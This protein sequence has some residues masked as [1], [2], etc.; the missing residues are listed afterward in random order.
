MS[1]RHKL[2][3]W[4][5]TR[6]GAL[7]RLGV[8]SL[9]TSLTLLALGAI[10]AF[11]IPLP[12]RLGVEDSTL[13]TYADGT[14]AHLELSRDDDRWR[15]GI[16]LEEVDP[17]YV[18]ALILL[19]DQ[20]FW[21]HPGVDPIAIGRAT[22]SNLTHG[23]VVSGASTIT[24]QLVRM[25]EPRPRTLSSKCIEALRA[26]QLELRLSKKEILEHYVRFA[27]YGRNIEGL[28]AASMAYFGHR[29]TALSNSEIAILLAVPQAPNTRYPST[30]NL[31]RLQRARDQVASELLAAGALFID[32][33]LP[34]ARG[35]R[36]AHE[37]L[38]RDPLPPE[39]LPFPREIPHLAQ[40][41]ARTHPSS[42][43][44]RTSI[45]R[46]LQ[47]NLERL[48][49]ERRGDLKRAQIHH[50]AVVVA[51]QKSDE[52]VGL[53]GNLGFDDEH[54]SQIAAFDT[55]RSTGSLLK[56]V[57]MALAID[58]GLTHPEQLV[59]DVPIERQRWRPSNF[60]GEF[61]GLVKL[62]DALIRSLNIPFILLIEELGVEKLLHTLRLAR[63]THL[64]DRPGHYGLNI[65]VGGVDATPL[66]MASLYAAFA[67][68]GEHRRLKILRGEGLEEDSRQL[69]T[70]GANWLVDRELAR[71][72]RPDLPWRGERQAAAVSAPIH[73]KTGTSND[74][75]D[76]WS[77]GH[78]GDYTVAVWLGNLDHASSGALVGAQTAAPLM[79]DV[80][81]ALLSARTEEPVAHHRPPEEL[82]SI[83]VCSYSGD[84]P[85][86]ACPHT[87]TI[88]APVQSVP[89][90]SCALHREIEVL[91]ESGELTRRACRG[92]R[93]VETRRVL[94]LDEEVRSYLSA[95]DRAASQLPSWARG[96]QPQSADRAPEFL[97]PARGRRVLLI[98]GIPPE[99]QRVPFA[100]RSSATGSALNWF[101]DGEFIG[102]TMDD[103]ELWWVPSPGS[104][105]ILV[106]DDTGRASMRPLVVESR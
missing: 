9:I 76:A 75:H 95:A 79:F 96:C 68:G 56:P 89:T 12:E 5:A 39:L 98:P 106:M 45:D 41:L 105:E 66:E 2:L 59:R 29:A 44:H 55:A 77:V 88:L 78:G 52:V 74:N 87:K 49:I 33:D 46:T 19:E 97:S 16:P 91:K 85:S 58:E 28:D 36:Q 94:D 4:L 90:R 30:Q 50:G 48:V 102:K 17:H 26:M 81:E 10:L 60:S 7:K 18:E 32:E 61:D 80:M 35:Q 20:R 71:R 15:V 34:E 6:R 31:P 24:M 93:E 23:E 40:W 47:A 92:G 69:W 101:V 67:R 65:A 27:P 38:L 21:Y 104:H 3:S 11:V 99:R 22:L 103:E 57:M 86:S 37:A 14:P 82:T 72:E 83:E 51:R 25:L 70:R 42:R 8:V 54:G 13:V 73:W 64:V 53:V 1:V 100:A 62:G 63:L 43:I 84:I